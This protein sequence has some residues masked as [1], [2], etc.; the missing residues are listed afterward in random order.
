MMTKRF[1]KP[2]SVSLLKAMRYVTVQVPTQDGGTEKVRV[3]I[4]KEI[5][6]TRG[7]MNTILGDHPQ[8][9]FFWNHARQVTIA[10]VRRAEDHY[11]QTRSRFYLAYRHKFSEEHKTFTDKSLEAEA[12]TNDKV[13]HAR[14]KLNALKDQ[15]GL[16]TAICD[17]LEHRRY[18]LTQMAGSNR[19][20]PL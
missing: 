8:Q 1:K 6:L 18:C 16:L 7:D 5:S 9:A 12:Y 10:L 2:M 15:L 19:S 13:T 14:S 3:D 17:M 4:R 20:R 11:E